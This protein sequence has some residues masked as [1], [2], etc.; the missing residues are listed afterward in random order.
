MESRA[1]V[2]CRVST[3]L[4]S[5]SIENQLSEL[6]RY[7]AQR[8]WEIHK[9]YV[10]EGIS[11]AKDRRPALDALMS[12]ARRRR[13][14]VVAVL[15]FD[16][17]ARSARHLINALAEFR[18]IGID[19]CSV[20]DGIDTSTVYGRAMFTIA[21]AFAEL[22]RELIRERVTLG[23]K[24]AKERGK[25][26]GRPKV[27]FDLA[28]AQ[29]LVREGQSYTAIGRELGV[30]RMT[31]ARAIAQKQVILGGPISDNISDGGSRPVPVGILCKA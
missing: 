12:D 4:Q 17:F 27:A 20:V 3:N 6:R 13:F 31:V 28:K 21:G 8:G 1:A 25:V 10:D 22:E 18:E 24:K 29:T 2:Y 5:Q 30:S 14:S 9:E 11:G 19:F 23:V 15:K 7:A 26:L 16:R